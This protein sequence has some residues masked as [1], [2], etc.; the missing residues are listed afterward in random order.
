MFTRLRYFLLLD[1]S[2][3]Y[4]TQTLELLGTLADTT[5]LAFQLLER[6]KSSICRPEKFHHGIKPAGIPNHTA[7]VCWEMHLLIPAVPAAKL[8]TAAAN[9]AISRAATTGRPIPVEGPLSLKEVTTGRPI[10]VEGPLREVTTGRPI[11]VEGPL[12]EVT[13]GRPIPVE[14]L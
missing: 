11:P 2:V 14:G 5:N 9:I 6:G 10:P 8:Y 12:R 1:K 7:K 4:P 3:L 13:T